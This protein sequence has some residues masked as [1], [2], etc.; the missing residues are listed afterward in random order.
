MLMTQNKSSLV[1]ESWCYQTLKKDEEMKE[2]KKHFK[3][4]KFKVYTVS[5]QQF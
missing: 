4:E 2:M 5:V 3:G 1:S